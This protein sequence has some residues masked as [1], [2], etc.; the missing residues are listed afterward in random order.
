[1]TL[2]QDTTF[3]TDE[4]EPQTV[5]TSTVDV[6]YTADTGKPVLVSATYNATDKRLVLTFNK[7]VKADATAI[8]TKVK[9]TDAVVIANGNSAGTDTLDIAKMTTP[10]NTYSTILTFTDTTSIITATNTLSP[11]S[12]IYFAKDA[13][14]D[15]AGNKNDAVTSANALPITYIDQTAPTVA[16]ATATQLSL[17][18]V[19]ITFDKPVTKATAEVA[20]N[21][22]VKAPGA[23]DLTVT[24]VELLADEVTAIITVAEEAAIGIN[25]T[26]TVTNV[27]S[28]YGNVA[29]AAP[30][31]KAT[32]TP[33]TPAPGAGPDLNKVKFVDV[34][35]NYKIDAG[36]KLELTYDQ[37]IVISGVT[38][39]DFTLAI[40]TGSAV[41]T[42]GTGATFVAGAT[43]DQLVITLGTGVNISFGNTIQ[44]V[45]T[46]HIKSLD[47]VN[48]I[49]GTPIRI[50]SPDETAPA[51]TKAEYEDTNADGKVSQGDRVVLTFSKAMDR[52]KD[53]NLL[54][55]GVSNTDDVDATLLTDNANVKLDDGVT[56]ATAE[57]LDATTMR[58]TLGATPNLDSSA[59]TAYLGT[60]KLSGGQKA[61]VTDLWGNPLANSTSTPAATVVPVEKTD[62][63]RPTI[64]SVAI[65]AANPNGNLAAGDKIVFT[66][67]E[68]V[69]LGTVAIGD[70]SVYVGPTPTPTNKA[71]S[72][73][74]S[75]TTVTYTID[76]A[77]AVLAIAIQDISTIT[78]A[79]SCAAKI[80]DAS[81][82]T[83]VIPAGFGL[84]PTVS[85]L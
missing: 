78:I 72:W 25:Y 38:K 83:T 6:A 68:A 71:G 47:G 61:S 64:E 55:G 62:K 16:P 80:S 29:V 51:I 57:W 82:N 2:T 53:A 44:Q 70:I 45:S 19:K 34:N 54:L 3:K 77:D 5:L 84:V 15:A 60:A 56:K 46:P 79:S 36:D 76:A 21:Y 20:A 7:P 12:K 67:S 74:V 27:T 1:V 11:K 31:N 39:D 66:M 28:K 9:I 40:G 4:A 23:T 30:N 59:S 73:T 58:I 69:N 42:F 32:W 41:T 49:V 17:T 85:K 8:G 50:A 48:A 43:S 14:V 75:G 24:G 10:T 35:S 63:V 81:G 37:P 18:K 65:K 33:T 13:F 22:T 26:I 52:S